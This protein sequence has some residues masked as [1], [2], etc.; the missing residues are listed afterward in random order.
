M[1]LFS[2]VTGN[3]FA[4][5]SIT[6]FT[7]DGLVTYLDAANTQSYSGAG[8]MWH[9]L[10]GY[11]NHA[12]LQSGSVNFQSGYFNLN[13]QYFSTGQLFTGRGPQSFSLGVWI[14]TNLNSSYGKII[15]FENAPVG[16]GSLKYDRMIYMSSDYRLHFGVFDN[17]IIVLS[18]N[19]SYNDNL[20]HYA[21][22]T[23][24]ESD[25]IMRF[26]IDG[27]LVSEQSDVTYAQRYAGYWRIGGYKLIGWPYVDNNNYWSGN[28]AQVQIY[29]REL[30][31]Y[32]ILGNYK[33]AQNSFQ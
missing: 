2:T 24:S 10:S 14:Q 3:Y 22:A 30:T 18:S 27:E 20:W 8:T 29:N 13:Q 25:K 15:G 16:T 9:D 7:H 11:G 28:Y 12:T 23:Y 19:A 33:S 1:P 32:E 5:K 4:G 26:Y 21:T 6:G 17:D 31:S